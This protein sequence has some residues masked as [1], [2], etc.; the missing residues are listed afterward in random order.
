MKG[1]HN[2]TPMPCPILQPFFSFLSHVNQPRDSTR[3]PRE[4]LQKSSREE[5]VGS[6]AQNKTSKQAVCKP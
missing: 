5:I 3:K 1:Y 4:A 2:M 6:V